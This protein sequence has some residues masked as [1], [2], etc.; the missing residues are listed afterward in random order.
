[1]DIGAFLYSKTGQ[2]N[3]GNIRISGFFINRNG[4]VLFTFDETAGIGTNIQ[5]TY[6]SIIKA[7]ELAA[8]LKPDKL[9]VAASDDLV[10]KQINNECTTKSEKLIEL[11]NRVNEAVNNLGCKVIFK[12]VNKQ[13]MVK[14]YLTMESSVSSNNKKTIGVGRKKVKC[15]R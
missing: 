6:L 13:Q 14:Y 11:K 4:D 7:L 3:P 1:M 12:W 15:S 5:A 10:I 2:S 8:E 9:L